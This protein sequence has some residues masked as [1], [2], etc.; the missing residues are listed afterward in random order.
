MGSESYFLIKRHSDRLW[1][2]SRCGQKIGTA[3]NVVHAID[4]ANRLSETEYSLYQ[5]K[6]RVLFAD[7][8]PVET[9][10]SA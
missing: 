8:D 10:S 5:R 7:D 3:G 2:I 1:S 6:T 9:P 4:F